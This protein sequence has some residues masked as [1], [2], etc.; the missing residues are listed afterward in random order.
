M[1]NRS[2]F[3]HEISCRIQITNC[4]V[5]DCEIR[6]QIRRTFIY[7]SSTSVGCC[8][9]RDISTFNFKFELFSTVVV[10]LTLN[11]NRT[12]LQTNASISA[13]S[14]NGK[15]N[16]F[17]QLHRFG[18]KDWK[19]NCNFKVC[20]S[21]RNTISIL[22]LIMGQR[23]CEST[24][25]RFWLNCISCVTCNKICIT[26]C[27]GSNRFYNITIST[28]ILALVGN[29]TSAEEVQLPGPICLF[30][31]VCSR[32]RKL[33]PIYSGMSSIQLTVRF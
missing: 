1:L 18:A 31:C 33:E 20:R 22:K 17:C 24:I 9:T 30:F 3:N 4:E 16:T 29:A 28:H 13:L 27:W 14:R 26:T 5:S 19:Y 32:R 11:G 12:C 25:N 2:V 23:K 6:S 8:H 7:Q 21:Q 10:T 15:I